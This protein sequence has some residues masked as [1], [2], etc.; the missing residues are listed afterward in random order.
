MVSPGLFSSRSRTVPCIERRY[1]YRLG[2]AVVVFALAVYFGPFGSDAAH[3]LF[4]TFGGGAYAFGSMPFSVPAMIAA[5]VPTLVFCYAF[6]DYIERGFSR[7]APYVF[8]RTPKKFA[9]LFRRMLK[10]GA[11]SFLYNVLGSAVAL[12]LFALSALGRPD[13]IG[14]A[15]MRGWEEMAAF[16]LS[17]CALNT[18]AQLALLI[19][20]NV[21]SLRFDTTACFVAVMALHF[22]V[23]LALVSLP[24]EA[25]SAFAAWMPTAQGVYA[26]HDTSVNL[27]LL[28][29]GVISGFS[30]AFS[31]S[32]LALVLGVEVFASGIYIRRFEFF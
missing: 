7:S 21:L 5:G 10:L 14:D 24:S 15:S 9:W 6:S 28:G 30:L 3:A 16:L 2:L 12:G 25:V 26:W 18:L 1:A 8:T 29:Q 11:F 17:A 22:A 4:L 23:L 20:V 27:A 19:P 31:Y 13:C 32:Y